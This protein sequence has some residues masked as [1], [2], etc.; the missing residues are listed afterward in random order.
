LCLNT[1]S[2]PYD[3]Y[4]FIVNQYSSRIDDSLVALGKDFPEYL[5]NVAPN[6]IDKLPMII[7]S[8]AEYQYQKSFAIDPMVTLLACCYKIQQLL[9]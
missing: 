3:N 5:R 2:N 7:I 4:K 8:V 6:K 1:S 9:K